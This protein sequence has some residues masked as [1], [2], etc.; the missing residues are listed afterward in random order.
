VFCFFI[1]VLLGSTNESTDLISL[2]DPDDQISTPETLQPLAGPATRSTDENSNPASF[3][4]SDVQTD[5]LTASGNENSDEPF[6]E[7]GSC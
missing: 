6:Y 2:E 3:Q 5:T 1:D 7:F 4:V